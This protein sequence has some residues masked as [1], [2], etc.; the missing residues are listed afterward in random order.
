MESPATLEASLQALE[1]Q[2]LRLQTA[3]DQTQVLFQESPGAAFLL[4]P[5]G[6]ILDVNVRGAA[7]LGS[8][9]EVLQG[10]RLAQSLAPASQPTFAALLARVFE[11]R[12]RQTGEVQVLT[13]GGEVLDI[14]LEASPQ[15][16]GGESPCCHLTLTDVTAFKLAHRAL[17]DTQ[18]AQETQLQDQALKLRQL[19]EE[20]E[21]VMLASGREMEATLTRAESFLTLSRQHPETPSYLA[22]A[23]DG[24]RQTQGLLESLKQ[25]MQMRFLRARMRSVDLGRVLREVLKDVQDQMAGRD[26]Q[27]TSEAL[28][29][30]YGDSQALQIILHEYLSNALKFTRTQPRIR[31]HV[32]VQETE[33][34]YRIGVEDNGV[35]FNMRQ[36]DKAFELF[37]RLHPSA[38]YEGTG[39]GLPVVRRLCERFGGRAWGEGKVDQGATFWFAWPKTPAGK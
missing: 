23:E 31:L 16:S 24:V 27:V 9:R 13:S 2:V 10:R 1:A 39:L 8:T 18:Q 6:R 28:P 17:W 4:I 36:K 22:H 34:E 32:L 25:Y 5:Q 12:G 14:A 11:G 35:G 29:T 33:T 3:L 30:V 37:G 26:V 15:Q 19:Q 21:S 38:E 20:F 7:L